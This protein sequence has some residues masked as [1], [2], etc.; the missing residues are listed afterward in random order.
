[1]NASY[2]NCHKPGH[3][4]IRCPEPPRYTRCF[5]C[6]RV[7][8]TAN[9]HYF[10]CENKQFKSRYINLE[11]SIRPATLVADLKISTCSSLHLLDGSRQIDLSSDFPPMQIDANHGLLLGKA[12]HIK[13]FQWYPNIE[14]QCVINVM[15][16]HN[17][18]R[19]SIN[20]K[21]DVFIINKKIR[22]RENGSIQY[23]TEPVENE[24]R[25]A[26]LTLKVETER[27]FDVTI[28]AFNRNFTFEVHQDH[29][30][31]LQPNWTT[32]ECTICYENMLEQS[33]KMTACGHLFCTRCIHLSLA[34]KNEC[35]FC[36]KNVRS[37]ELR[38]IFL[39]N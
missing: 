5:D 11:Q 19:L 3:H 9:D 36:R 16:C 13:Y 8:E 23:R 25:P 6:S 4:S 1:M 21:G 7:C 18:V 20:F 22:V 30:E 27:R 39:H 24:I 29:I 35:P 32:L 31:Y 33:V 15:N 17:D 10:R 12:K 26:E 28:Y 14:R 2:F 38:D 34:E 37:N